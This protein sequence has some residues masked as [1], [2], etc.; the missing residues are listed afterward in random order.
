MNV[1]DDEINAEYKKEKLLIYIEVENKNIN[2]RCKRLFKYLNDEFKNNFYKEIKYKLNNED[3]IIRCVEDK[4]II[5]FYID[6]KKLII[7]NFN[8]IYKNEN[9]GFYINKYIKILIIRM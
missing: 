2:L 1:D 9:D 6:Y 5:F 8:N 4:A 7:K 3:V